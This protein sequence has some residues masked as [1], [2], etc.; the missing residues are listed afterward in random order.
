MN[1]PP[2]PVNELPV[3]SIEGAVEAVSSSTPQIKFVK[4]SWRHRLQEL[5]LKLRLNAFMATQISSFLIEP[6]ADEDKGIVVWKKVPG[7]K[8]VTFIP[9]RCGICLDPADF[10]ER[11]TKDPLYARYLCEA[12]KGG[13]KKTKRHKEGNVTNVQIQG[14][15]DQ[16]E[17]TGEAPAQA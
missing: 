8:D 3:A 2:A 12:H 17:V 11:C 7:G 6:L 16:G 13:Q 1:Y 9:R 14:E 4:K 5:N 15:P 10:V